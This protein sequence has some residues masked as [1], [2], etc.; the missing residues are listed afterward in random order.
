MIEQC[1]DIQISNNLSRSVQ[2]CIKTSDYL[3]GSCPDQG[4]QVYYEYE[5]RDQCDASLYF[6]IYRGASPPSIQFFVIY[7]DFHSEFSCLKSFK[8]T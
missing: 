7:S 3:P 2:L 6:D 1:E 4:Y 8:H 5:I